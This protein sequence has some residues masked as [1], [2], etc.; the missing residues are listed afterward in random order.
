MTAVD[1]DPAPTDDPLLLLED[2]TR[3]AT[4]AFWAALAFFVVF[5]LIKL[6]EL[7]PKSLTLDLGIQYHLVGETARGAIPII[8]FEHGWNVLGWYVGAAMFL[9]VGGNPG[10]YAW[11]W[12]YVSALFLAA[13]AILA[14]GRR[15]RLTAPWLLALAVA[16][17]ILTNPPNGKYA[18]PSLWLL[19]LLP[20]GRWRT[21]PRAI[22]VR[23]VLGAL[24]ILMHV[25]LT[26]MLVT[27]L[28]AF[29][30]FGRRD[31]DLRDRLVLAAAAPV[32]ALVAF[33]GQ[34]VVYDLLGM[35]PRALI[36]FVVLDRSNTVP[37]KNF[38]YH[39]LKPRVLEQ[40]LYPA[41]L[42]LPVIP[43]V[44]RRVSDPTRLAIALHL[45]M[46]LTT[47]RKADPSH[48]W[49]AATLMAVVLVLVAHDLWRQ[50]GDIEAE[51]RAGPAAV[52]PAVAGVAWF[53][54]GLLVTFRFPSLLAWPAFLTWVLAAIVAG[55]VLSRRSG[56]WTSA[57][58]V[59]GAAV[60]MVS[61]LVV[62][63][64]DLAGADHDPQVADITAAVEGTIDRCLGPDRR[65]WVVPHPLGLYESLEL[66]EATPFYLFWDGFRAE[67]PR[68]NRM[69]EAGE[70]PTVIVVNN[71]PVDLQPELG[72]I[73]GRRYDLCLET[74]SE[75]YNDL[76]R[77]Y[78]WKGP[79]RWLA[80]TRSRS[81]SGPR[82]S[83]SRPRRSCG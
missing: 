8:D 3:A 72:A 43:A 63:T 83:T 47:I 64:V 67:F 15:L 17:F 23:A 66:E 80:R 5:T 57:G 21:G 34:V 69:I 44:W 75:V 62:R 81:S 11:M 2:R 27:G 79:H 7:P 49:G 12:H 50:R 74:R 28:A 52:G 55:H 38:G 24:T 18:I 59:A 46:S 1:A 9:L 32:G 45:S 40:W 70:V 20:V 51:L 42:F 56:L 30:L 58:A 26:I 14:I 76:V 71:V 25:D 4:V 10:L 60:L 65:A 78:T 16:Q 13:I 33:A 53:G 82:R 35:S 39:L 77:V 41:T 6:V 36:D 31:Q 73:I 61:S 68:L 29:E 48:T 54:L 19:A 37:G 22:A